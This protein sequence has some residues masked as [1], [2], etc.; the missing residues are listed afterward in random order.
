MSGP[1]QETAIVFDCHGDRLVGLLHT[2]ETHR[3]AP[4]G[5]VIVVGGPQYRVG[6]HRHFVETA[7]AL[8]ADGHAVLRFDLR[9]MGDSEGSRAHFEDIAP[10]I[11]SAV[12]ALCSAVPTL[13]GVIVWGLCNAAPPIASYAARD[14]RV[15]GVVLL[16]PWVRE[17]QSYD[18]T[19][20]RNYYSRRLLQRDFWANLLRGRA[21]VRDFAALALRKLR[22]LAG[23]SGAGLPASRNSRLVDR[24]VDGMAQSQVHTLLVLSGDDLTAQ[25]FE[26]EA[27]KLPAWR[28]IESRPRFALRRLPLADHTFSTADARAELLAVTRAWL[29]Q[30]VPATAPKPTPDATVAQPV[31][32]G[33]R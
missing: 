1:R 19:L 4:L 5:V 8:C 23:A 15:T 11:A 7:R 25:E 28:D 14:P 2:P 13:S 12:T 16:N 6:G 21:H 33:G 10:E 29:D 9:G 27:R 18:T 20:L 3:H 30:A 32:A 31:L 22:G 24:M 17:Q 26:A